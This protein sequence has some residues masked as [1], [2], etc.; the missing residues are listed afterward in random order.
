MKDTHTHAFF[1]TH[2]RFSRIKSMDVF[3][4]E[5][6]HDFLLTVSVKYSAG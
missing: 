5:D 2:S 1:L 3:T 6:L 4:V